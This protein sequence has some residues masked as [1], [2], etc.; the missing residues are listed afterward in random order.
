MA[1]DWD[2]LLDSVSVKDQIA[3]WQVRHSLDGYAKELTLTAADP[4]FYD[5]F[6]FTARPELRLEVKVKDGASWVS[7][8][9]FYAEQPGIAAGPDG[10]GGQ[11]LWGRSSAAKAGPPFAVKVSQTWDT[12]T[13]A[14]TIM[15]DM[16]AVAGVSI[17]V[18]MTDFP[19]YA[20]SYVVDRMY[21]IDV[22]IQLASYAGAVVGC[23]SA[24]GL[25]V[26]QKVFHP[27]TSDHTLTDTE[28]A[29]MSESV[30]YPEFGN[31]IKVSAGGGNS[32]W[33][34]T[35]AALDGGECLP[36]D[37]AST[38]KLL[39]FVTSMGQAAPDNTIVTW[40]ADSGV[41]L[42]SATSPTQPYLISNVI[43]KADNYYQ[44]TVDY[45][46]SAVVGIWA[47]ADLQHTKNFWDATK[48]GCTI[49]GTV[50]TVDSPFQYCDQTL[51]IAYKAAG[52]AVN[53]VT[54][55]ATAAD[56]TVTAEAGGAQGGIDVKMGNPCA[57][58]SS[59]TLRQSPAASICI[60]NEVDVLVAAEMY[61]GPATGMTAKF[62]LTGCG[63]LSSTKKTLGSV[64]VKNEIGYVANDIS[65]VSQVTCA[66]FPAS[67][68][69]VYR[70]T[71]TAKSTNLYSSYSGK[72]IDLVGVV[73]NGTEVWIDYAA[74][75]ATAV[76]WRAATT[77]EDCDAELSVRIANGTEAGL[78]ETV[79]LSAYDCTVIDSLDPDDP[80]PD[81]EPEPEPEPEPDD[82]DQP[83]DPE[84]FDLD[85][86]DLGVD[87]DAD[88]TGG[89]GDPT[90]GTD[91]GP[92]SSPDDS[93]PSDGIESASGGLMDDCTAIILGRIANYD[94]ALPEDKD[95]ARF[96][97][98]SS[99]LDCPV[100]ENG[101]NV[102][103][104]YDDT[105]YGSGQ[106]GCQSAKPRARMPG[107]RH[108][109][110]WEKVPW[111]PTKI[112][113]RRPLPRHRA[114]Q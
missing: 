34:V 12:D 105:N 99:G 80:D 20:G 87:P 60:G 57:C 61:G 8:G 82:P 10:M 90:G 40:S 81:A 18:Q 65:G 62:S 63:T 74:A 31:R 85:S 77:S 13:T 86:D 67:A 9:E 104:T 64:A 33:G 89:T 83:D 32:E 22:I 24:G 114:L 113:A 92:D 66:I 55:G 15:E 91:G 36:A 79:S 107:R 96:G 73:A 42:A 69:A 95:A 97:V 38:G 75:G 14:E 112:P 68:P 47:Y 44:V 6:D 45:P 56:V 109:A 19:V 53:T 5:E 103:D 1:L 27:G 54:A 29:G 51:V 25:V 98:S 100:D 4:D 106:H 30:E 43:H 102:S 46:V 70:T 3:S 101:C 26:R 76:T 84:D 11:S 88:E 94:D 2:I 37:G 52:C 49:D 93:Y 110:M 16:A 59:M 111:Q 72:V 21:P 78:T 71:D 23:T 17:D 50:I 48:S 7:L 58:G 39:A 28:M 108:V 41:T 35:V